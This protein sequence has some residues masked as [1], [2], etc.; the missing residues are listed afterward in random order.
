MSWGTAQARDRR[1]K[2]ALEALKHRSKKQELAVQTAKRER[3]NASAFDKPKFDK[4]V[5][6]EEREYARMVDEAAAI[7]KNMGKGTCAMNKRVRKP[8]TGEAK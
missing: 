8:K 5:E 1:R 6:L 3:L 2:V 7:G 4:K